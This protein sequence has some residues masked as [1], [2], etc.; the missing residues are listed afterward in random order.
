MVVRRGTTRTV[1]LIGR[2]AIKIPTFSRWE[3]FLRGLLGNLQETMFTKLNSPFLCPVVLSVAGGF[4]NV[5]P[6]TTPLTESQFN[7][8]DY[9]TWIK[10]GRDLP[11]GEWIL[12]VENK[13]DSF[14]L[15]NGKIVAVDYGDL[16]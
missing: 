12:P 9:A 1:V 6:R 11:D 13:I 2:W 7:S 8:I 15:F 10:N 16:S 4:L 5:M 3:L 14:G